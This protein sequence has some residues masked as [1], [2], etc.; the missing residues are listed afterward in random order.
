MAGLG[1]VCTHVAAVLFYLETSFGL[2]G[3]ATCT[4]DKCQ[5]VIPAYQKSIPYAPVKDL[6]FTSAKGKK[7]KID[8]ALAD[9][10]PSVAKCPR[11]P[12]AVN[13]PSDDELVKFYKTLSECG[14]KPAI[15]SVTLPYAN[16]FQPKT[17]RSN[18]PQLLPELYKEEYLEMGYMKLLDTCC[19]I[20]VKLTSEMVDAV[21]RATRGQSG[22]NL[23]FKYRA[24]RITA[25]RM[26][27]VCHSDPA[28]PAQSLIK[29]ICYPEAFKFV[30]A[31]TSWGCRHEKCARDTYVSHMM[32]K[33]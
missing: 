30:S 21:E 20:E 25:S 32:A 17:S 22:S 24:G 7:R 3:K 16:D 14:S 12:V 2:Q 19:G 29:V 1:E 4:Q 18:F 10:T 9:P 13:P 33:H 8:C 27:S 28:N 11:K 31:A 6:D 26:K 15:L 23:W 5:W